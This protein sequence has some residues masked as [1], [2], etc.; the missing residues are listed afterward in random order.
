MYLPG[1]NGF[2]RIVWD[3]GRRY[4]YHDGHRFYRKWEKGS[5]I[6]W[7]C[8]WYPRNRCSAK[9]TTRIVNGYE[10]MKISHSMH[11]HASEINTMKIS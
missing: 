1:F 7:T 4:L 6:Y 2:A 10:M 9:I 8:S 5:N 11:S 3:G